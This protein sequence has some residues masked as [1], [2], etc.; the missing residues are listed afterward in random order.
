MGCH[1]RLIAGGWG[2]YSCMV[3][4]VVVVVGMLGVHGMTR[5]YMRAWRRVGIWVGIWGAYTVQR[6]RGRGE[7]GWLGA[8]GGV[9]GVGGLWI[10]GD[11]HRL[12]SRL[13]NVLC[14]MCC[15]L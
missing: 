12:G 6:A 11:W 8:W 10:G 1:C 5:G 4:V 13:Q 14:C 3:V 15:S 7:V 2:G 9:G